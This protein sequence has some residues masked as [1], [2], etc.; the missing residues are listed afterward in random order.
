MLGRDEKCSQG[1]SILKNFAQG[2]DFASRKSI[3]EA[4]EWIR[5]I[6]WY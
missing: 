3:T 1:L 4:R 2:F 5:F 6:H